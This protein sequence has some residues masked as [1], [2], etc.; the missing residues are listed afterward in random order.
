VLVCDGA[1]S[2]TTPATVLP[3]SVQIL[4]LPP[5]SPELNPIPSG[6]QQATR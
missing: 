3:E 4:T 5:Y 6:E 1:A 2:H